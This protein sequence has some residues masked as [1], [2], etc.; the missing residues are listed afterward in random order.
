MSLHSTAPS[1]PE[2]LQGIFFI[3]LCCFRRQAFNGIFGLLLHLW[4]LLLRPQCCGVSLPRTSAADVSAFRRLELLRCV[5]MSSLGLSDD[6]RFFGTV[7]SS[8]CFST[9]AAP[10]PALLACVTRFS[11]GSRSSP[12]C[13]C[14][15]EGI[16]FSFFVPGSTVPKWRILLKHITEYGEMEVHCDGYGQAHCRLSL[17]NSL[18]GN[19]YGCTEP[20][21]SF[22]QCLHRNTPGPTERTALREKSEHCRVPRAGGHARVHN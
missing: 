1:L 8:G 20:L 10:C 14:G 2:I 15:T 22:N 12:M 13:V 18:S 9:H 16:S 5:C 17:A 11:P 7:P 4:P 3:G 6:F 19:F 21:E